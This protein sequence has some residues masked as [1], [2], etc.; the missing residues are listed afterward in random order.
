[1]TGWRRFALLVLFVTLALTPLALAAA[2]HA[3]VRIGIGS[4]TPWQPGGPRGYWIYL[5]IP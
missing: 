5:K 3:G 1:M 2:Y 4:D